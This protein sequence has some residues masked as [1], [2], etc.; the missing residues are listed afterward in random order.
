MA[1]ATAPPD[2]RMRIPLHDTK[3]TCDVTDFAYGMPAGNACLNPVA[4]KAAPPPRDQ[5]TMFYVIHTA[6]DRTPPYPH[7]RHGSRRHA[8]ITRTQGAES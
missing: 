2:P 5:P 7:D 1:L 4:A 8:A 3:L 6:N